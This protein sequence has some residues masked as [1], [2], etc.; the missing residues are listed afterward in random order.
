MIAER[1]L[2]AV[3]ANTFL[4]E[5]LA[6]PDQRPVAAAADPARSVL[7]AAVSGGR[8]FA[9]MVA[10]EKEILGANLWRY[11]TSRAIVNALPPSQERM[12]FF[13]EL[14]IAL[15]HEWHPDELFMIFTAY[16][17]EADT[18]GPSP[19]VIMAGLDFAEGEM[20][21]LRALAHV[22]FVNRLA[23]VLDIVGGHL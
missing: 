12:G 10:T 23:E 16:F 17:D 14:C 20:A 21:I 11:D 9:P 4:A 6:G 7:A 8:G 13:E 22:V 2:F 3:R 5:E 15:K 19:T 18:H 1:P